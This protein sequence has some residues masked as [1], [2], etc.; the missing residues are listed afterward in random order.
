ML[1]H[2]C[3]VKVTKNRHVKIII[4]L[5]AIVHSLCV[6]QHSVEASNARKIPSAFNYTQCIFD[7]VFSIC[8]D[9]ARRG[10]AFTYDEMENV[11]K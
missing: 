4:F 2:A 9:A 1:P 3:I 5:E 10:M 8:T 7:N 11:R 6:L